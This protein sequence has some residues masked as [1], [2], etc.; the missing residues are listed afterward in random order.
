[1]SQR[2]LIV[3]DD[4][5]LR[6]RIR[7]ILARSGYDTLLATTFQDGK[8]VLASDTLDLVITDV[9]LGEFNGLQ[10]LITNPR[11]IPAIVVTAFPDPVLAEEARSI[12]AGHLA[13]P[14]LP[15]ALLD[16]VKDKI[17]G[18]PDASAFTGNRRWARKQV[19]GAMPARVHN[20]PARI[21][22]ISYGGMRLELERGS[23]DEVP[24][25]FSVNL[26]SADVAVN[27][28]L[29]WKSRISDRSWMCGA[30]VSEPNDAA[31]LAWCGVV[32]MIA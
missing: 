14:F 9:R 25:S 5:G 31:A 21:L 16:L 4:V 1:M 3:G 29:V 8:R 18:L 23:D 20:A 26:P 22:D 2:I 27:V 10:L 17:A 30:A 7:N 11:P 28:A 12:G 13:S 15:S 24:E 32:D 19:P 6:I